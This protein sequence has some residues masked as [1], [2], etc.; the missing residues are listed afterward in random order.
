M[1]HFFIL[2]TF[3]VSAG[4]PSPAERWSERP[5]DLQEL[6]VPHPEATFFVRAQGSS[7]VLAGIHDSDVLVVDRSLPATHGS[8]IVALLRGSFIVKRL[9]YQDGTILLQSEHHRY[10]TFAVTPQMRFEIWGVV[11][12]VLHPLHASLQLPLSSPRGLP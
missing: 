7:M 1:D 8:I 9:L 4:F 2:L 11:T 6:L 12:C 3:S 5:L 10:P